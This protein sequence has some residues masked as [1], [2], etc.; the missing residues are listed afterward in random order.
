MSLVVM[1]AM[2]LGFLHDR[3]AVVMALVLP[4][5]VF[6]V[7]AAIFAGATG[8]QL[9][10]TVA[11]ADEIR[12]ADSQRLL[13]ALA[14]DPALALRADDTLS[15]AEVRRLVRQ[16]SVDAGLIVRRDG[17]ALGDLTGPGRAPLVVVSDP[18]R[19]VAARVLAGQIQ[20]V[21][22][23]ALSDVAL[24]GVARLLAEGFVTLEPAQQQELAGGLE[25]LRQATLAAEAAGA[26]PAG[27][28]ESLLDD[29]PTRPEVGQSH[30]AYYAGAVAI[31]FLLFAA[32]HGALTLLEE[33]DSGLLDRVLAGPGG[34]GAVI[35][36]KF[37]FLVAQGSVQVTVIF[38]LAWAVYGV[39]LPGHLGPYALVTLAAA[40]AAAGLALAITTAC[41][42]RRQAQ[43]LA[44][45]VVL[46]V[47]AVGGSMVPRFLMPPLMQQLGWLTPTAWALEA[48]TSVFWR[49][50]PLER[51]M[52]PVVLLVV[53]GALS[54]VVALRL[55][56]RFETI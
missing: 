5:A 42:S 1:R 49:G 37:L 16:G 3:G 32:V 7:F 45:I 15:A 51:L 39:D 33:R 29:Q 35:T 24:G 34:M 41:S 50:D 38:L 27:V 30:V 36:G 54:L 55:A 8:E 20:E 23:A 11:V 18:V 13:R 21:Y 10:I 4:V 46:I 6:L 28:L 31:L 19:A 44:N 52:L 12:S 26:S 48:Y 40:G 43:T 17:R 14:R 47:S 53:S 56:R 2:L 22:F 25:A 9:R